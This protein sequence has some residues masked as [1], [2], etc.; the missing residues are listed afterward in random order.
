[1]TSKL[2]RFVHKFIVSEVPDEMAA[3]L[4]CNVA[5]CPDGRYD[6]CPNRLAQEARQKFLQSVAEHL[7]PKP[8]PVSCHTDQ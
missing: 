5:Q 8:L 7:L 4:D 3:C 1:M 2:N 6:S